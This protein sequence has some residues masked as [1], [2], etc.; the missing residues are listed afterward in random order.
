MALNLFYVMKLGP[1]SLLRIIPQKWG[2]KTLNFV[3]LI[4]VMER[5]NEAN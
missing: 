4:F 2:K 5:P 3:L 1:N